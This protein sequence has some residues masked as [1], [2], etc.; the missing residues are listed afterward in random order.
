MIPENKVPACHWIKVPQS[1]DAT[2][3]EG[4]VGEVTM[5]ARAGPGPE[6]ECRGCKNAIAEVSAKVGLD[7][8]RVSKLCK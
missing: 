7:L 3:A 8:S 4:K 1:G 6:V 2:P 5:L